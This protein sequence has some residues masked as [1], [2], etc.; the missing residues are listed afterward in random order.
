VYEE[1]EQAYGYHLKVGNS[2]YGFADYE[3]QASRILGQNVSDLTMYTL[4]LGAKETFGKLELFFVAGYTYIE[5]ENDS[6]VQQEI[7]F[8][9]LV[10]NHN[11]ESRPIPVTVP[12]DYDQDSYETT[13]EIDG[14]FM[15]RVGIAYALTESIKLSGAYKYFTADEH[16]E[17]YDE[18]QK[19]NGGWWQ[20]SYGRDLSSFEIGISYEF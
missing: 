3:A 15:G 9:E 17:L 7:I 19:P 1:L 5:N 11:V 6:I 20:E 13:Y 4:G 14:G 10:R 2:I 16:I 12:S 8:T 18:G